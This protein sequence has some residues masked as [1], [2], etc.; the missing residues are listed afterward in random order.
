MFH[1]PPLISNLDLLLKKFHFTE[2]AP[3]R[4]AT[5]SDSLC[6]TAFPVN[7]VAADITPFYSHVKTIVQD[8]FLDHL[9]IAG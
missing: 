2:Q 4:P 1:I 7:G 8:D 6:L 3:F 5:I 9:T